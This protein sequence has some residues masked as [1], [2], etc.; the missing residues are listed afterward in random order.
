[1]Y[2]CG[3]VWVARGGGGGSLFYDQILV[4]LFYFCNPLAEEERTGCFTIIVF[5]LSC[6]G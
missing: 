3:C 4:L 5:L 2:V 6:G 1:M